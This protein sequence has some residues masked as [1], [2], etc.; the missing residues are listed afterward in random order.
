MFYRQPASAAPRLS[1]STAPPDSEPK[2]VAEMLTTDGGRN[3]DVRPR[4]A[5]ST[6]AQ[7]RATSWSEAGLDG[8]IAAQEVGEGARLTG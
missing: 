7:G 4:A 5:P 3:A 6:L 8:G 2:L 1:A